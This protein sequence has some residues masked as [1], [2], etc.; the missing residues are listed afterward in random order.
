MSDSQV[1]ERLFANLDGEERARVRVALDDMGIVPR[2]HDERRAFRN[3]RAASDAGLW[4]VSPF[5]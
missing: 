4:G 3:R 2:E 1:L 5:D